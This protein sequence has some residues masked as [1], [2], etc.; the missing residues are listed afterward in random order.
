MKS[1]ATQA[2][3]LQAAAGADLAGLP[4]FLTRP[5]A[6]KLVRERY[7]PVSPRSL[8]TWPLL[9]RRVNGRALHETA[10]VIAVAKAMIA[11]SPSIRG[12][13]RTSN[14]ES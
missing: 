11:A 13:R 7:F 1:D 10:E 14:P 8:E 6:A 12:G 9:T 4:K 5:E 2:T 3:P